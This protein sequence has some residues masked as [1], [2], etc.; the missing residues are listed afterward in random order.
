MNNVSSK[1]LNRVFLL[2]EV[3]VGILILI[4]WSL[5]Y[6]LLRLRYKSTNRQKHIPSVVLFR[7]FVWIANVSN[8]FI[9]K[10][11]YYKK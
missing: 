8:K 6:P 3:V 4:V 1:I 2:F 10:N 7:A 5:L 9:F 11:N